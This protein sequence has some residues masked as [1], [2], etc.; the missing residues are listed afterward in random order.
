[1][2]ERWRLRKKPRFERLVQRRPIRRETHVN[3][4]LCQVRPYRRIG[5]RGSFAVS[6]A[7]NGFARPVSNI[8]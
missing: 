1:V 2:Y 8:E 4:P 3:G 7:Q 6:P 5:A